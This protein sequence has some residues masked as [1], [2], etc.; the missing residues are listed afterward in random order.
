MKCSSINLGK[1]RVQGYLIIL[2]GQHS[3][4]VTSAFFT[5]NMDRLARA[6]PGRNSVA[7]ATVGAAGACSILFTQIE[8]QMN[9]HTHPF[10]ILTPFSSP[11]Q[12][13]PMHNNVKCMQ[14]SS[15]TAK[16]GG[17][18]IKTLKNAAKGIAHLLPFLQAPRK[19][20]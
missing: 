19:Q 15:K 6:L 18:C 1:G 9:T 7:L 4:L 16:K 11:F 3:N 13:L 14:I 17:L 8:L 10:G 2:S 5:V 12:M 20:I